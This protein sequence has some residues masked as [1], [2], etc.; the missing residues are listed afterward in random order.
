MGKR[1]EKS[2]AAKARAWDL[3]DFIETHPDEHFQG[4]WISL[5]P[6]MDY[7]L[8]KSEIPTFKPELLE[9]VRFESPWCGTA[10]CVA[11]W[12]SLLAGDKPVTRKMR[13]D[14]PALEERHWLHES[15]LVI[16]ADTG[17][18]REVRVRAIELLELTPLEAEELFSGGNSKLTIRG[19]LEKYFGPRPA[20]PNKYARAQ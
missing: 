7:D 8:D 1:K 11:G 16:S 12:T 2:A 13:A 3:W 17:R 5:P 20:G 14:N 15:P 18:A 9:D 10:A 6:N 19:L 4:T